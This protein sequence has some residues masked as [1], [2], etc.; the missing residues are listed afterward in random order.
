[1][2]RPWAG[3][4]YL[5]QSLKPELGGLR[6]ETG[7]EASP[8][9]AAV[10]VSSLVPLQITA[11]TPASLAICAAA[12]LLRMPPEPKAEVRSPIWS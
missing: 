11:G 6:R 4:A 12:T 2:S 8:P 10:R 1:M 9:A 3:L 5:S 7:A